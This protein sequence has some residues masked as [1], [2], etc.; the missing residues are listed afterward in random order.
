MRVFP[1]RMAA[2]FRLCVQRHFLLQRF[3][4][5]IYTGNSRVAR[6]VMR[7]AAE[8]LLLAMAG[9][10]AKA[11]PRPELI[12]IVDAVNTGMLVYRDA[13]RSMMLPSLRIFHWAKRYFETHY[14][15][16]FR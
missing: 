14:L 12:C 5:I 2:F 15:R 6:I 11:K 7:A 1:C 3:D 16:E 8:N 13:K 4:H 10:P 9:K